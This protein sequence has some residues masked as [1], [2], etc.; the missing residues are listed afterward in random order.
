MCE[1]KNASVG[2]GEKKKK[3][4]KEQFLLQPSLTRARPRLSIGRDR[5]QYATDSSS[6][7]YSGKRG[8]KGERKR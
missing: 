3:K 8:E 4:N 2:G 1:R 5:G 6:G 7:A